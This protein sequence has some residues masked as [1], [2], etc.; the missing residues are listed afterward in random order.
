MEA[1]ENDKNE[2]KFDHFFTFD[3]AFLDADFAADDFFFFFAGG[4]SVVVVV[5]A[6]AAAVVGPSDD[7]VPPSDFVKAAVV[8]PAFVSAAAAAAVVAGVPPT[9]GL[10]FFVASVAGAAAGFGGHP[11][12]PLVLDKGCNRSRICSNGTPFTIDATFAHPSRNKLG[13]SI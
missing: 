13:M 11:G 6:A 2:W 12:P 10:V 1:N 7:E 3:A 9:L 4:S 5:W 8:N